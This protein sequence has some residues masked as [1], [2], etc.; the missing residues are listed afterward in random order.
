MTGNSETSVRVVTPS[1]EK[2]DGHVHVGEEEGVHDREAD[3]EEE[4][5]KKMI[6]GHPLY[7]LLLES[8]INCLKVC[9]GERGD[10][11]GTTTTSTDTTTNVTEDNANI[12]A[13][14]A[15]LTSPSSS[16]L[17]Q[18]MEAYCNSLN[19]LKEA[20][21]NPLKEASSF[22]DSVQAQLEELT[23]DSDDSKQG[24]NQTESSIVIK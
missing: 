2:G 8:H 7:G 22:I 6:L 18:F 1:D 13:L 20:M 12:K 16:D 21:E 3:K 19:N 23:G 4:A 24:P 10:E 14:E 9:S 11:I 15:A 17:D 5:L